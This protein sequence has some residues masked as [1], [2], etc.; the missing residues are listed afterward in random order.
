MLERFFRKKNYLFLFL[1]DVII[2][3]VIKRDLKKIVSCSTE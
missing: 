1:S 3:E 2:Q